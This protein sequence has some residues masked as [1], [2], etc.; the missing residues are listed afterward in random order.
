MTSEQMAALL[1]EAADQIDRA[2]PPPPPLMDTI[3]DLYPAWEISRE[4]RASRPDA[5]VARQGRVELTAPTAAGLLVRLE[6]HE[7]SRL[8]GEYSGVYRVWRTDRF[9]MATALVEGLEPTLIEDSAHA[10]SR[11]LTNPGPR[12]GAPFPREAHP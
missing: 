11:K 1:G 2:L 10:L 8:Q 4:A 9:W 3:A 12:Y 7:L 5:W 6:D